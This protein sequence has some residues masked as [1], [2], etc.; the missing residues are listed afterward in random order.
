LGIGGLTPLRWNNAYLSRLE[1]DGLVVDNNTVSTTVGNDDLI[2]TANGTGKISIPSNNVLID[3]NL[4]VTQDLTVTTGT[5]FLKDTTI[6]GTMTY[7]GAI[8]QTGDTTISGNY[9]VT[10]HITSTGYLQLPQVRIENNVVSTTTTNTDLELQANGTG[11]VV[12]EGI[13]ISDNNIQ[14]V[15]TNS[16]ITLTPQGTGSVVINSNQSLQIP[17]GT[18]ADRPGTLVGTTATTGMIR[19]NTDLAQYEGY[20]GTYWIKLSGVQ[21]L[22]GNT[23][24]KAESTLGANDNTLYFYA[25]GNLMVTI[26]ATKM[27]AERLQTSNLDLTGNTISSITTDSNLNLTAT[28]TGGVR[29]GNLR[30]YNNT[31][32]NISNNAVTEFTETGTGFV[33]IAGTNGV[34]IPSGDG[35][36]ERPLN[37]EIGMT[38]FN[39][40]GQLV[41]VYNGTTWGSVAGASGG[42][43]SVEANELGIAAAL[44]LG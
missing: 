12:I 24:I 14:S 32:T 9:E 17:V 6:V 21:D 40:D 3:Q 44:I 26:D 13:K 7:T 30:I 19:Y 34:V 39:T 41:E 31:I 15:V 23:Y 43:T 10:G 18:T 2:L 28:G 36:L 42:V 29:V 5:T 11:N 1:V 20:N 8:T 38:R 4:T 27:F 33:R 35:F 25:D 22:D 37:P 16:N